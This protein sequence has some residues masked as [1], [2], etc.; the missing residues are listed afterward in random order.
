MERGGTR[1]LA[2][3]QPAAPRLVLGVR[4]PLRRAGVRALRSARHAGDPVPALPD[5]P[6]VAGAADEARAVS[7]RGVIAA[8]PD[9]R[10]ELC[11][12]ERS[13]FASCAC[14]LRLCPECGAPTRP[15]PGGW[16]VAEDQ[17]RRP[18]PAAAG[19]PTSPG[20]PP[21]PA[22]R[23]DGRPV[24]PAAPARPSAGGA[25]APRMSPI[26]RAALPQLEAAAVAWA[27]SASQVQLDELSERLGAWD[28]ETLR[29]LAGAVLAALDASRA[30]QG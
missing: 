5:H 11:G 10:C 16:Y 7:S 21:D 22:P 24:A 14:G 15:G 23:S 9:R 3:A 27:A 17:L 6:A 19:A 13:A 2:P 20:A 1:E 18:E 28:P 12:A 26:L 8:E 4:T 30:R 29:R 25:P